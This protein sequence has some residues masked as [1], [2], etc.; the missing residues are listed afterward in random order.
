MHVHAA[1]RPDNETWG[2]RMA[3]KPAKPSP[4]PHWWWCVIYVAVLVV[5]YRIAGHHHVLPKHQF[6]AGSGLTVLVLLTILA[7]AAEHSLE[8]LAP[9]LQVTKFIP[10]TADKALAVAS[11]TTLVGVAVCAHFGLFLLHGLGW[12][13]PN[14]QVDAFVSGVAFSGGTKVL[15]GIATSLKPSTG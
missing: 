3:D 15:H 4:Q 5:A 7:Q 1:K 12:N 11:F 2:P 6:N 14:L 10:S 8:P 9:A 13:V